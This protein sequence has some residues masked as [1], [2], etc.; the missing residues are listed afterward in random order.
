MLVASSTRET[1]VVSDADVAEKDQIEPV[2]VTGSPMC[3]TFCD[4]IMTMMRNA[5]RMCEV[6]HKN[7]VEQCVRHLEEREM[8]QV[9]GKA[10]WFFLREDL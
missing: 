5:N 8:C 1:S 6:K 7:L 9:L 2:L 4:A 3:Q 10:G